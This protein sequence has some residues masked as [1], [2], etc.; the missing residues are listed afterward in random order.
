MQQPY[1]VPPALPSHAYNTYSIYSPRDVLIKTACEQV[2][3]EAWRD[4]WKSPIDES[5]ACGRTGQ[6]PVCGW[7]QVGKRPCGSCQAY[8]IRSR[9]GRT[10]SEQRTGAGITV[11]TFARGQRCFEE[12]RT[13]PETYTVA[14]GDWRSSQLI[15]TH[16]RPIDWVEDMR[17][18]Q[19]K[20][21]DQMKQG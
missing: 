12:H 16:T 20:L 3:C 2:G 11:F 5:T 7:V 8:Y 19:D 15:R 6:V 4:G 1:R 14:H 18:H 9:S 13:R 21:A 10:F 17:L